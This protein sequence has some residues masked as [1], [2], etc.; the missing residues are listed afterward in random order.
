MLKEIAI[1]GHDYWTAIQYLDLLSTKHLIGQS[2]GNAVRDEQAIYQIE[3]AELFLLLKDTTNT[4]QTL[5]Q[6]A[7]YSKKGWRMMY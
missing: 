6:I 4:L 2:C 3:K 7:L 1:Q 5:G